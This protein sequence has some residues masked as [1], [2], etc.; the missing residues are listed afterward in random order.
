MKWSTT[1]NECH[2]ATLM[3][4]EHHLVNYYSHNRITRLLLGKTNSPETRQKLLVNHG[5]NRIERKIVTVP[6]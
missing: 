4:S 6:C 2:I 3:N 1:R 5:A